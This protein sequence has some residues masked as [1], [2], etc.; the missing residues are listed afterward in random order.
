T[1]SRH[2]PCLARFRRAS[3]ERHR[4]ACFGLCMR[5]ERRGRTCDPRVSDGLMYVCD[6]ADDRIQVF[7]KTGTLV[8]VIPVVPGTGV[9]LGIGGAPALGTAGSAWDVAFSLDTKQKFMFEADGGNEIVHIMDRA[10]GTILADF[11]TPG[12]QAGQFTF[13]HSISR[14]SKGN[15][16]TG[17][18][19][20]GRRIQKF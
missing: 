19:I 16:Y 8:R 14:D 20:N 5:E 9:T 1:A 7:T 15:L 11:G 12:L 3:L 13:L 10:L 4:Y 18:T 6:R 17:E 2:P